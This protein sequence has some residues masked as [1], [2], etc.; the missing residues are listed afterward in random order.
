MRAPRQIWR[1]VSALLF[2]TLLVAG[3]GPGQRL[4]MAPHN[5]NI[6]NDAPA[7]AQQDRQQIATLLDAVAA[8]HGLT[9]Q[10]DFPSEDVVA[11]YL[12]P[13]KG[14]GLSLSALMMM[15]GRAITV[16][17]APVALGLANNPQRQQVIT[18]TDTALQQAFGSRFVPVQP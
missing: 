12:S 17:V 5:V 18:D 1:A 2:A 11:L 14:L 4:A 6:T 13:E 8:K 9:K 15:E 7:Q 10:P 16:T 3:C